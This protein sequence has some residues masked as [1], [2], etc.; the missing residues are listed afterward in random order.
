MPSII[1]YTGYI[2][3]EEAAR[4]KNVQVRAINE[5][6][7]RHLIPY[8]RVDGFVYIK[9]DTH[10]G[11]SSP[12]SIALNKLRWIPRVARK[13]KFIPERLYEQVLIG[14]ITG[15]VVVDHVFVIEDE[16]ELVNF[17]KTCYKRHPKKRY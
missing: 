11:A 5:Q 4:R 15:V 13:N 17:L 10:T 2:T 16:P 1:H 9:D 7:R 6:I 3:R 12:V 14:N 8:L